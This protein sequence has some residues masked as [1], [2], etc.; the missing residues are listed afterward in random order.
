MKKIEAEKESGYEK[1]GPTAWGVAYFR[2]FSDIEYAREI[3][4]ELDGVVKPTDP[5]QIEFMESAR[6]RS[7]L[8]PQFEARYK[9]INR[10]LAENKTNQILELAAG[11]AGRG[12]AMAEEDPSLQYV[13]VDLPVMAAHKR[14]LLQNLF[15]KGKAKPQSNL[16]VEDGDALDENS[17]L[18]ATR[19]FKSGPISVVNEGLLRYLNFDEKS[20]V[21][22]N[23]HAL[24]EKFGGAWITSDITLK[25]IL[26]Y[27]REREDGRATVKAMSGIDVEANSFESEEAARKFFEDLGFSVERHGFLEVASELVSP[28][29][30]G[31]SDQQIEEMLKQAVVFVMRVKN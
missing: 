31:L 6:K 27:E 21:A 30:L 29:R 10:L 5:V 8:A 24:L 9:L 16:H 17:L 11:L 14:E 18:A 13:E 26:A 28:K 12:L 19:H 25:K 15:S 20:A 1:I 23:V 22:R 3:F 2:T 4:E 7:N